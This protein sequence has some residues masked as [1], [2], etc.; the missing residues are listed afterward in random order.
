MITTEIR[1]RRPAL[2]GGSFDPL[3]I[4]HMHLADAAL[5]SGHFDGVF[6]VPARQS[7]HK[8]NGYHASDEDRLGMV[9]TAIEGREGMHLLTWELEREGPSYTITTVRR[10]RGLI[11]P[12]VRPGLIIGDDLIADFETWRGYEQLI[13]NTVLTIG[14]RPAAGS[15][16]GDDPLLE[17]LEKLGATYELLSN[18]HLSI[19]SSEIRKRVANGD[20]FRDLVPRPVYDIIETRHLYR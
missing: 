1:T 16:D 9:E 14:A 5:A 17:R 4:G 7:P 10:M 18:A 12:E 15:P 11:D 19:S 13:A 3:H 8:D 6:F 20:A 2:F